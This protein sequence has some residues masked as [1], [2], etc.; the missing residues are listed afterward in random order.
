MRGDADSGR[1]AQSRQRFRSIVTMLTRA[2][3]ARPASRSLARAFAVKRFT[4][5]IV[6]CGGSATAFP[7]LCVGVQ[8][9]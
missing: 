1:V 3:T 5:A 7:I 4:R 8:T 9:I 2:R 6:E